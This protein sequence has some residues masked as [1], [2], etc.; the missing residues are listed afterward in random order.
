MRE[1]HGQSGTSTTLTYSSWKAMRARCASGNYA[2]RVTVCARWESYTLFLEDM[3][4]RP[5]ADHSIERKDNGGNY[6]PSNC[7]W[8]TEAE[9]QRNRSN[10]RFITHGGET[11]CVTDWAARLGLDP[12]RIFSRLER[13]WSEERAVTA[14]KSSK[15][16]KL[17]YAGRA[18]PIQ[19]WAAERGLGRNTIRRRLDRGMTVGRALGMEV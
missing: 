19:D 10:N 14:G 1:R 5:S 16:A 12:R 17:E 4:E 11:L 8:A 7:R 6:E 18:M 15:W 9:Q 2:G 13:G 3:G